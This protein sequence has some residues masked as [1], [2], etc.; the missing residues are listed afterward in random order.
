MTVEA[1]SLGWAVQVGLI[2]FERR[3]GYLN[4]SFSMCLMHMSDG[5]APAMSA[6]LDGPK[7]RLNVP[8]AQSDNPLSAMVFLQTG[9]RRKFPVYVA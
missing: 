5:L 8:M 6:L 4:I 1:I 3:I 2:T 9:D 7:D